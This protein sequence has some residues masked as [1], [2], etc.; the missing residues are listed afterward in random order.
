MH[1]FILGTTISMTSALSNRDCN[2]YPRQRA[3]FCIVS[4]VE[5]VRGPGHKHE[6]DSGPR[7]PFPS[8]REPVCDCESRLQPEMEIP[9]HACARARA[10][11]AQQGKSAPQPAPIHISPHGPSL[12]PSLPDL[13][14]PTIF[15]FATT[16]LVP[17]VGIWR[18]R[19]IAG[20][21]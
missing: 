8:Q 19:L 7:R 6:H 11:P 17:S 5:L 9:F 12:Q 10:R 4:L 20:N 16:G 21:L 14:E 18:L 2:T 13:R 3:G 1:S 15:H